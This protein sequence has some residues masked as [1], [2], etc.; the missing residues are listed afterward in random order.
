MKYI[1]KT[2]GFFNLQE[3]I[4]R[5]FE[6]VS[7]RRKSACF[8]SEYGWFPPTDIYEIDD[9]YIVVSEIPGVSS[10]DMSIDIAE[11]ILTIKG[12]R[13][14]PDDSGETRQRLERHF[15]SFERSFSLP[16]MINSGEAKA[17]F[18]NGLL[19]ISIPK[20]EEVKPKRISI[21]NVE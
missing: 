7:G 8:L 2:N 19:R 15:G 1:N 9:S 6:E 21:V 4:N 20:A 13:N 5:L 10:K 14:R 17:S 11:N 3:E 12:K 18:N 16:A